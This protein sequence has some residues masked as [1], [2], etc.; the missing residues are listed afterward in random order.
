MAGALPPL[1]VL[2]AFRAPLTSIPL[3]PAPR[4][5]GGERMDGE[6]LET[7]W[8]ILKNWIEDE[9]GAEHR[10]Q[11]PALF[12]VEAALHTLCEGGESAASRSLSRAIPP[13]EGCS[14]CG[15]CR[16]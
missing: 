13:R 1:D 9:V 5:G 7:Y 4:D 8:T 12:M 6:Q 15:A 3:S 10:E 2:F 14:T 11:C 16:R